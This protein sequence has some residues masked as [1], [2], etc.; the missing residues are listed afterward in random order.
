LPEEMTLETAGGIA[1]IAAII[2]DAVSIFLRLFNQIQEIPQALDDLQADIDRL[3]KAVTL[4]RDAKNNQRQIHPQNIPTGANGIVDVFQNLCSK[5]ATEVDQRAQNR[6]IFGYNW[7]FMYLVFFQQRRMRN[8]SKCIQICLLE[9]S[10]VASIA[11]WYVEILRD[12]IVPLRIL[13]S[14]C[15]QA[16]LDPPCFHHRRDEN[17]DVRE[18]N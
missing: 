6:F 15:R 9:I 10:V 17:D 11:A 4:L 1:G 5:F 7:K 2:I 18:S 12:P 3:E 13:T 8:I 16:R 14:Y